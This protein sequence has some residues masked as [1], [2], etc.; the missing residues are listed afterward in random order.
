MLLIARGADANIASKWGSSPL[1]VGSQEGFAKVTQVLLGAGAVLNVSK[2]ESGQGALWSAAFG[3]HKEV[4]RVLLK[5]GAIVDV[6]DV[7]GRTPLIAASQ[8]GHAD[9]VQILLEGGA[10]PN[11]VRGLYSPV[12]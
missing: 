7:K 8:N 4:V 9:V 11:K 1:L 10:D 3:G 2:T 6:P 5:G 12:V